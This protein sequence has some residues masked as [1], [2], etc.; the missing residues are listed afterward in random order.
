MPSIEVKD[1]IRELRRQGFTVEQTARGHWRACPPESHHQIVL[2]SSK[3]G[4]P[5]AMKNNITRLKKSGFAPPWAEENMTKYEQHIV[6]AFKA[7]CAETKQGASPA[8][9]TD[10][11]H[12]KGVL[13]ELDTVID[14]ERQM[15]SLRNRGL[16]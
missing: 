9:V 6:D 10:H 13:A 15:R 4:D 14:V 3:Y 12:K 2:L 11:M 16:L 7:V 1:L 8:E 5:R